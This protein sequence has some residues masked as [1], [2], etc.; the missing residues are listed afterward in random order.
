MSVTEVKLKDGGFA[1]LKGNALKLSKLVS[2]MADEE[3]APIVEIRSALL[4]RWPD[5]FHFKIEVGG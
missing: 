3:D 2:K 4:A 1:R 5:G